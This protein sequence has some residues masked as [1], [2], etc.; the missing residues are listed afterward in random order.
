MLIAQEENGIIKSKSL[1]TYNTMEWPKKNKNYK[2]SVMNNTYIRLKIKTIY[3]SIQNVK[4]KN[5]KKL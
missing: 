2:S 1:S 5:K 4:N 3:K